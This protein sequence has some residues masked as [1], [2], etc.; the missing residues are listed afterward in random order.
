VKRLLALVV[1][2]LVVA[3][4]G[5]AVFKYT[6]R[7]GH[8]ADPPEIPADVTDPPIR[9]VIA[10]K[11]AAVIADRRSATAWGEL[12]MAFDTHEL[13][14]QAQVCYERAME[15]DPPDARWPFLLA[16]VLNWR[17]KAEPNKEEA[18]RLYR[19]AADRTPPTPAHTWT[20][21]L[22]LADL[23]TELD[24]ADEAAPL[25]RR[26]FDADPENPWAAYR[27]A[28]LLADSGRTKEAIRM[29]QTLASSPY[30]RKKTAVA[31]AELYRRL[32]KATEADS[33]EHKAGLLPRDE[34]W[35][36]PYANPVAELRRGRAVLI[37]TYFA[38]ERAQHV[39][40]VMATATALADQYPSVES[41]L[42]LLRA[43]INIGELTAALAVAEDVLRVEPRAPTAH[44]FLGLARLGLADRAEAEGRKADADRLLAQA[45]EALGESVRLKPD[46]AP[47]YL[48][49]AKVLLRLGRLPEAEKAARAGVA[50]RPEEWEVHLMLSDVLA[51]R[52]RKAEA[53]T[54]AEQAVKL[55]PPNEPRA[56]KALEALKK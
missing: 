52:G 5:Y 44:S 17:K 24:R 4:V 26:A 53:V 51:A 49:W 50:S 3:A 39:A 46:Y 19:L 7:A 20:A 27:A 16:E 35:P 8:R 54:A 41:Q 40:G 45:A 43:M 38:L 37:D 56:R 47:G 14:E 32:G 25:Y 2:L 9:K 36:N 34:S 18:V 30:T 1:A 10:A 42:L 55:A 31:L 22:C 21:T 29:Y 13:W 33:Y 6:V 15:L 23:L 11:R 12:G 48:Y 28:R